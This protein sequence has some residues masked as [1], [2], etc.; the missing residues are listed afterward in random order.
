MMNTY[1]V[2]RRGIAA[3]ILPTPQVKAII[4]PDDRFSFVALSPSFKT[5]VP[6]VSY[7]EHIKADV[8]IMHHDYRLLDA[9]EHMGVVGWNN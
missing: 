5:V 6:R 4:Q 2:V 7:A 1:Y 3:S 8:P 9:G